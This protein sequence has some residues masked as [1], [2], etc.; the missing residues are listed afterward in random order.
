MK[1]FGHHAIEEALKNYKTGR[2][3]LTSQNSRNLKLEQLARQSNIK[4]FWISPKEMLHLTGSKEEKAFFESNEKEN[5]KI[6]RKFI[7]KTLKDYFNNWEKKDNLLVVLLD[8]ITDMNNV[9]AILRTCDKM[10]VDLV[11]N[12]QHGNAPLGHS[13]HKTS[14]GASDYVPQLSVGNLRQTIES[15]QEFGFWVYTADLKGERLGKADLNS[16]KI[17]IVMGSED[18]GPRSLTNKIADG[19]L[20]IPCGGNVDSFNV[21]VATAIILYEIRQQQKFF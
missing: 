16:N 12:S 17:A 18:K 6:S 3:F 4:I 14:S 13:A 21:G 19:I 9:G 5:K 10:E 15:L 1:I 8:G 20:T 7:G 11:I 2:I